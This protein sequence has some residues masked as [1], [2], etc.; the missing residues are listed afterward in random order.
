LFRILAEDLKAVQTHDPSATSAIATLLV[1]TP[2]HAIL[3]YRLA[4]WM[5]A[6]L[7]VPVIPRLIS[8]V[9]RFWTGV[10]IHPGAKIGRRFF[11]DHGTGLVIGETSEVGD[12]CVFF[13]NVT[14][15]GTGK[16]RGKR[17]PTVRDNVFVGTGATLL[18]P[19]TVGSNVK[20]GAN[21]F[22]RMHD[23]PSGCTAAGTPARIVK[24][25]GVAIDEELPRTRLSDRSIPMSISNE[26][27]APATEGS[28]A[29]SDS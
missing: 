14:L 3:L 28:E 11:I 4:H 12:D 27:P 13:H 9:G 20:I 10:E 18:G 5:H 19:I 17:H 7:H 24:R 1:H 23:V 8:A 21:S 16:H 2:L 22:I 15:G 6:V 26:V 25:D 29:R